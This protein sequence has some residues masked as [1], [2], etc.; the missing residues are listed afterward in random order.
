MGMETIYIIY[1]LALYGKFIILFIIDVSIS[2][3]K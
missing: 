1:I 2:I 3:Q